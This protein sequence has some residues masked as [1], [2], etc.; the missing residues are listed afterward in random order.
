MADATERFANRV[1]NYVRYRPRYPKEIL[2][3]LEL[4]REFA[5]KLSDR[6][7]TGRCLPDKAIDVLDEAGA[8]IRLRSMTKPPNLAQLRQLLETGGGSSLDVAG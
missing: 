2:E 1:E 5:A 3:R 6:Y 4:V 8:R 7:I